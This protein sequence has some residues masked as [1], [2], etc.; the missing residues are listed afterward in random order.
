MT[1]GNHQ[2]A[3]KSLYRTAAKVRI[4]ALLLT[5][6]KKDQAVSPNLLRS[7]KLSYNSM[8]TVNST[9]FEKWTVYNKFCNG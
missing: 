8:K 9:I 2:I 5:V 3:P 6:F 4:I 7:L 1:I